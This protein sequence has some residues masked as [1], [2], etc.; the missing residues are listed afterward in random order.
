MVKAE[1]IAAVARL[2]DATVIRTTACFL[3]GSD[4]GHP[5]VGMVPQTKNAVIACGGGC[6]GIL[7]GPAMGQAAAALVL[8][9]EPAVS[10]AAF[11]PDRAKAGPGSSLPPKLLALLAANP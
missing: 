11:D 3:A 4:D 7:N 9:E 8:G 6:W 10:L 2:K 1:S 5:V